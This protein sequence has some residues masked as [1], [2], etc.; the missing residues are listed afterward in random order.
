MQFQPVETSR[1]LW[2]GSWS[3]V[4]RKPV[5][6]GPYP[7]PPFLDWEPGILPGGPETNL[8][9]RG[10]NRHTHRDWQNRTL[11]GWTK[12]TCCFSKSKIAEEFLLGSGGLRT[13][14]GPIRMWVWSL[15][16]L[17]GLRIWCCYELWYRPA[18]VA[19][20]WPLAWEPPYA[21]WTK[22]TTTTTTK[23]SPNHFIWLNLIEG[24]QVQD[25]ISSYASSGVHTSTHY[26][27]KKI[28]T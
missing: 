22:T 25:S 18:A 24:S 27:Q 2:G 28:P 23:V 9:I 11:L 12:W 16:S 5:L 6:C 19:L 15:A 21:T 20:L 3:I 14:L 8:Q 1:C 26:W 7:L 4:L 13:Q 10:Q 17:N